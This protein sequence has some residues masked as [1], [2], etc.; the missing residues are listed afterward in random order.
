MGHR[1]HAAVTVA[2][3]EDALAGDEPGGHRP[4]H[5]AAS[6]V[7]GSGSPEGRKKRPAA[8]SVQAA[9]PRAVVYAPAGQGAQPCVYPALQAHADAASDAAGAPEFWGQGIAAAPPP[10]Q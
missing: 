1:A 10:T 4:P 8:Q 9:A 2:A 6:E 5:A 3:D 7:D